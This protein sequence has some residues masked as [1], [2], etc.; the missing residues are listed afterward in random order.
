MSITTLIINLIILA[1]IGFSVYKD[2][3][4]N[5][6]LIALLIIFIILLIL[7]IIF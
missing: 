7:N 5:K 6:I 4:K 3:G 2:G 1:L